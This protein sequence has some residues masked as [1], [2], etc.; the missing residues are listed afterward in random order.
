MIQMTDIREMI[1]ITEIPGIGT[2]T[3]EVL[4]N[5]NNPKLTLTLNTLSLNCQSTKILIIL[6]TGTCKLIPTTKV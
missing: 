2:T 3:P 5:G 6:R 1:E 4:A